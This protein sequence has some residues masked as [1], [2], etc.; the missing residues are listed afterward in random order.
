MSSPYP[1]DLGLLEYRIELSFGK[2]ASEIAQISTVYPPITPEM[3]GAGVPLAA[4]WIGSTG[5]WVPIWVFWWVTVPS[6][7]QR[8]DAER[9]SRRAWQSPL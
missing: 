2:K 5:P 4:I 9:D 6:G 8:A 7:I 1:D 3:K